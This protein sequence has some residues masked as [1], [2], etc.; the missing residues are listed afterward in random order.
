MKFKAQLLLLVLG[1]VMLVV[2]DASAQPRWGSGPVPRSGVCFYEDVSF[3]G[4]YFCARPGE[5]LPSIP[6]GLGNKISSIRILGRTEVVVFRTARFR[7]PSAQFGTDVRNLKT[8]GWNDSISSARIGNATYEWGRN[9]PPVWGNQP[10]PRQGACFYKDAGF[11]GQY[12]CVPRGASYTLVPPGFND[13]ISSIRLIRASGAMIF[14]DRD[15]SGR[16]SRIVADVPN[17]RGSW[18][19]RISSVRVF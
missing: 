2:G 8:E 1:L 3:R 11:R 17:L 6:S 18:G 13:Q 9:R 5:T 19:D 15:F 14:A 12:F 4:R 16:S 7:G 10:M